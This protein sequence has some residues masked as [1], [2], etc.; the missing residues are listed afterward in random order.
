MDS[1][2][3]EL[4]KTLRAYTYAILRA[5]KALAESLPEEAFEEE[6]ANIITRFF[7]PNGE[8]YEAVAALRKYVPRSDDRL[9]DI[10]VQNNLPRDHFDYTEDTSRN[11]NAIFAL[12]R[13]SD[14]QFLINLL[15]EALND[16]SPGGEH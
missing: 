2:P 12:I 7:R 8:A 1:I 13:V 9:I 4:Q 6:G 11:V 10:A 3:I 16:M 14:R 5:T 15:T